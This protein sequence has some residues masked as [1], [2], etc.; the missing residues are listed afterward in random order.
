M[1]KYISTDKLRDILRTVNTRIV[2]EIDAAIIFLL[3]YIGM[4]L[5]LAQTFIL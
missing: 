3:N 4:K 2:K 5:E 1:K